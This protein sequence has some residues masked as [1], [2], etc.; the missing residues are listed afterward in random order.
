MINPEKFLY[1]AENKRIDLENFRRNYKL[2]VDRQHRIYRNL[3]YAENKVLYSIEEHSAMP[4][5]PWL[6]CKRRVTLFWHATVRNR[7]KSKI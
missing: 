5:Q 7:T 4:K 6:N 3:S 1:S 2:S